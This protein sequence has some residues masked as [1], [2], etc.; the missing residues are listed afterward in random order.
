MATK[1]AMRGGVGGRLTI[2]ANLLCS[3]LHTRRGLRCLK[4]PMGLGIALTRAP[5]FSLCTSMNK[6]TSGYVT[7]TPSGDFGGRPIRLTL[8]TNMKVGCGVGSGL[9]LFTRPKMARR[10][11]ASSGL[12][13]M[14]STEPA[15][16]GLV[17]N[18][19]VACWPFDA[20][21]VGGAFLVLLALILS[22]LAYMDYDRRALSCGGPSMSLF[23]ER[24]GTKGCGAGDPGNFMR[25]PGFARGSVPALL[26]CTR[27]LALV[28]SF[29]LPPISTCC[30]NGIHL[31]RYV[32]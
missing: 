12:R 7:K 6:I 29:P 3:G 11:G 23:M 4:V 20:S 17:Y 26:G 14:H 15:G 31:N 21:I 19:H 27:S 30:D 8:A 16:F 24:L 9:T 10:F 18:L 1:L 22:L 25:M 5:G 28:A 13:A 2:R 32:L